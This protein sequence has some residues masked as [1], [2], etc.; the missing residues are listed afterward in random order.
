MIG[1]YVTVLSVKGRAL[2]TL[3]GVL[4]YINYTLKEAQPP[5]PHQPAGAFQLRHWEASLLCPEPTALRNGHF[6]LPCTHCP[7]MPR[8]GMGTYICSPDFSKQISASCPRAM[9]SV[10][11]GVSE[12]DVV[13]LKCHENT[14]PFSYQHTGAHNLRP[15][16]GVM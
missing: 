3:K 8:L 10:S 15:T 13:S 12:F 14:E 4:L 11:S 16:A 7:G 9:S 1:D 2:H 5:V 6:P